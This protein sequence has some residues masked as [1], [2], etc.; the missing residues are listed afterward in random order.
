MHGFGD[1]NAPIWLDEVKCTGEE[2][3]L[4]DCEH[5]AFGD[6]DCNHG[7]DIG[8]SCCKWNFRLLQSYP[9]KTTHIF[10]CHLYFP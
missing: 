6:T 7:E 9:E 2:R 10:L 8:V 4:E 5:N 1:P 3:R